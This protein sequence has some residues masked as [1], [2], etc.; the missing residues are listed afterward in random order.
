MDPNLHIG[1]IACR[2]YAI[3]R[4]GEDAFAYP[5]DPHSPHMTA[6]CRSCGARCSRTNTTRLCWTCWNALRQTRYCKQ[7]HDDWHR[8]P[9]GGR[10]CRTCDAERL[11]RRRAAKRAA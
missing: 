8:K 2:V 1:P 10:V 9:D 3:E 4:W 7:G 11:R 6:A 5:Y